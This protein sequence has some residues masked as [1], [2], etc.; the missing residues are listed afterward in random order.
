M[1]ASILLNVSKQPTKI[2]NSILKERGKKKKKKGKMITAYQF[3][4]ECSYVLAE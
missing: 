1:A 2:G 3:S 4:T